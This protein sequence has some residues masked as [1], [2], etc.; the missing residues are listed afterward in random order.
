MCASP[1]CCGCCEAWPES[2]LCDLDLIRKKERNE[3]VAP[4]T[5]EKQINVNNMVFQ[6][7][8]STKPLRISAKVSAVTRAVP[9]TAGSR[10]EHRS[11]F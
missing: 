5:M 3:L 4:T 1:E 11:Q 10:A 8:A 6:L 2:R 7:T 9:T